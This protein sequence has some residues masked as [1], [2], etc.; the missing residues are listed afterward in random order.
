MDEP[1]MPR[2]KSEIT[3]QQ[4]FI[5]IRLTEAQRELFYELGGPKWLRAHL[6]G[7][8]DQRFQDATKTDT[9]RTGSLVALLTARPKAIPP[10]NQ[11]D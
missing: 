4:G 5:G 9:K 11:T 1:V 3:G 10:K 2:P 6:A 7:I 8:L